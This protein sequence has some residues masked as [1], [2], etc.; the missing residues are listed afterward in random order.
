MDTSVLLWAVLSL[1]LALSTTPAHV[2][3]FES[4]CPPP[5]SNIWSTKST[6]LSNFSAGRWA[7]RARHEQPSAFKYESSFLSDCCSEG[8]QSLNP[9]NPHYPN[10]STTIVSKSFS[11]IV[12][13]G[14]TSLR[15]SS[16]DL[17]PSPYP[18]LCYGQISGDIT[19]HGFEK[20][21]VLAAGQ[22]G[23][24]PNLPIKSVKTIVDG[25]IVNEI[26]DNDVKTVDA[27]FD[28]AV[29]VKFWK[30]RPPLDQIYKNTVGRWGVVGRF[31]MGLCDN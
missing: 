24:I 1:R 10:S 19:H 16:S 27:M 7:S 23:L 26:A 15:A 3:I 21:H 5:E 30:D 25:E 22:F 8:K 18:N 17:S 28:T 6:T 13:G 12:T 9:P 20:S 2:A 4:F 11:N 14:T 31:V 29:L